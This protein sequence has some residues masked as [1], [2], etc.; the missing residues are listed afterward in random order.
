[1]L[2]P[3]IR[4]G[5][6]VVHDGKRLLH[7]LNRA[8]LP[9]PESFGWDT[10]LGAYLLNPQEKSYRLKALAPDW[11]EDAV[12]VCSLAAWQR[13]QVRERPR[14]PRVDLAVACSADC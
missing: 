9:L 14:P 12:S 7:L 1:M 5:D 8:G 2:A 3:E 6:C 10:M 11:E 4:K 13:R